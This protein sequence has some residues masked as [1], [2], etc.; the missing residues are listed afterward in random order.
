[1]NYRKIVGERI[2]L[3]PM[4]VDDV[5]Q[6]AHWINDIEVSK[7]LNMHHM[8]FSLQGELDYLTNT[9]QKGYNFAIVLK[10]GD[11]LLGSIS[12]MDV[13][14]KDRKATLGL[15][16][17]DAE[18]RSKGY[19]AEAIALILDYGFRWLNLHNIML[20]VFSTNPRGLAC[21]KK[22]GFKEF[23]RRREAVFFDGKWADEIHME[24][25]DREWFCRGDL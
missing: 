21:Y 19:G 1:M 22:V 23:G 5:E 9:A 10:D 15:F 3:S 4:S 11:R 13:N 20:Q 7:Y 8:M 2:Y 12:L 14:H 25:L 16:I 17:G 24:I 6:Y 18:Y